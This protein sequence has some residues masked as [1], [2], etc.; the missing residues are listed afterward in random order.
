MKVFIAHKTPRGYGEYEASRVRKTLKGACELSGAVTWVDSM[1]AFPEIV[2][3]ISPVDDYIVNEAKANDCK[4]VVSV[5]YSEFDQ[6]ASFFDVKAGDLDLKLKS[7]MVLEKADLVLAPNRKV[8]EKIAEYGIVRDVMVLSPS[9]NLSRFQI[10]DGSEREIFLRYYS[11][12][13]EQKIAISS[14][15]YSDKKTLA[16]LKSLANKMPNIRFFHFGTKNGRNP[17]IWLK[18]A[19]KKCPKNLTLCPVVADDLYRSAMLNASCY[20]VLDSSRPDCSAMYEA[21]ASKTGVVALGS[22]PWNEKLVDGVTGFIAQTEGEAILF[23]NRMIG[24]KEKEILKNAYEIAE[25]CCLEKLANALPAVYEDLL[26][27]KEVQ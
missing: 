17:K 14:F 5:G 20:L 3:F 26:N 4:I 2:H 1:L 25:S 19:Q 13:P 12:M 6:P 8:A 23:I 18:L 21:F 22:Q 7:L 11:L 24:G 9:V 15:D 16:T 10:E 27:K